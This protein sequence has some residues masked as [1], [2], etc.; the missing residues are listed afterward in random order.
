MLLNILQ[1]TGH[2]TKHYPS[3][4]ITSVEMEY[5]LLG[6]LVGWLQAGGLLSK[7][8]PLRL[9]AYGFFSRCLKKHSPLPSAA[10]DHRQD[11]LGKILGAWGPTSTPLQVASPETTRGELGPAT[12]P[13]WKLDGDF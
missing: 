2:I 7:K 9:V 4:N 3:Q 12:A 10:M 13:A 8:Q 6:T 11:W 1:S 5:T